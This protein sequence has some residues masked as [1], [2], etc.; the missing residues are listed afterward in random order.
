MTQYYKVNHQNNINMKIYQVTYTFLDHLKKSSS[1]TKSTL[2]SNIYYQANDRA[3][4]ER[5]AYSRFNRCFPEDRLLY[6]GIEEITI[7]R[8]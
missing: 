2:I 8:V 4:V 6:I 3:S 5:A 7:E 1:N